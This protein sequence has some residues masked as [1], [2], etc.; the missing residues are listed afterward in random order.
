LATVQLKV[1]YSA[2][3]KIFAL[4]I[5]RNAIDYPIFGGKVSIK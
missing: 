3:R 5:Y 2:R 1:V 4:N